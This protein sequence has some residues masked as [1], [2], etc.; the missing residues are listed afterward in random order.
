M[1]TSL[2]LC[3]AT[4]KNTLSLKIPYHLLVIS[5]IWAIIKMAGLLASPYTSAFP[6]GRDAKF[7]AAQTSVKSYRWHFKPLL[8]YS[9]FSQC[10]PRT[11]NSE[12]FKDCVL[13]DMPSQTNP[14][15]SCT[16]HSFRTCIWGL[17]LSYGSLFWM[18]IR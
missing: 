11:S 18:D 15:L 13:R 8:L 1:F 6:E 7:L 9:L 12:D 17:K 4:L 2:I 10:M 14:L 16:P 5:F 3:N